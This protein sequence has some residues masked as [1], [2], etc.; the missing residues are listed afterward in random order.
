MKY[1]KPQ[2]AVATATTGATPRGWCWFGFSCTS[3]VF[4]CAS[5][6]KCIGTF[7]CKKKY[8]Q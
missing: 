2:I 1:T 3:G 8:V 7:T 5:G 4:T 6:H